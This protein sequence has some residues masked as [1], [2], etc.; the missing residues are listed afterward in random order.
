MENVS[1]A[2]LKTEAPSL[3]T[4]LLSLSLQGLEVVG[5]SFQFFFKLGTFA[6]VFDQRQKKG[7]RQAKR[8]RREKGEGW[9][10]MRIESQSI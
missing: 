4:Y 5:H 3:L 7:G 9:G 6:N 8:K 2:R 1:S 10:K